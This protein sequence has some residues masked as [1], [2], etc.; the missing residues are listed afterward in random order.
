MPHELHSLLFDSQMGRHYCSSIHM[1]CDQ[2]KNSNSQP[3]LDLGFPGR[4]P[5]DLF[6]SS[7][8]PMS[9]TLHLFAVPGAIY[10]ML[11]SVSN[12]EKERDLPSGTY[13]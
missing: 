3:M 10:F 11:G 2:E 12:A 9:K 6:H 5:F 1:T 13:I 7:P 4:V 8:G